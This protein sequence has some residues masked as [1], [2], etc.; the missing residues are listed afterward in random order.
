LGFE[1]KKIIIGFLGDK[2]VGKT[3][4]AN[5][6]ALNGFYKISVKDKIAEF[7]SQLFSEEELRDNRD[8][9]FEE[10][11]QRGNRAHKGYWLNLVLITIP[12]NQDKIVFD[13]LTPQDLIGN[14]VKAYQIYRPNFSATTIPNTETIMN[15][16][17]LKSLTK[18]INDLIDSLSAK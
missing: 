10:I 18:K 3:T 11:R 5:I 12:D 13:D 14:V 8:K 16:G 9:I 15:D 4:C 17:N 2:D 6:L 1:V 7:A